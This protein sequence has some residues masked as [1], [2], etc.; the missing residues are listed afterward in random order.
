MWLMIERPQ[1]HFTGNFDNYYQVDHWVIEQDTPAYM[2]HDYIFFLIREG[3]GSIEI[4]GLQYEINGSSFCAISPLCVYKLTVA[5]GTKLTVDVIATPVYFV[6]HMDAHPPED[7]YK[8]VNTNRLTPFCSLTSEQF[9]IMDTA[10]EEFERESRIQDNV[11]K[12]MMLCISQQILYTYYLEIL[13]TY[14]IEESREEPIGYQIG[15]YLYYAN[16]LKPN[17]SKTAKKFGLT[18]R[19]MSIALQ[20]AYCADYNFI[21]QTCRILYAREMILRDISTKEIALQSGFQSQSSFF[22]TFKTITGVSFSEYRNALAELTG[23][24]GH[25]PIYVEVIRYIAENFKQPIN[26]KT[27]SDSL[28]LSTYAINYALEKRY[29]AGGSFAEQLRRLRLFYA[30]SL[31]ATTNMLVIDIAFYSGYESVHTFIRQFKN[32]FSVTPKEY[33]MEARKNEKS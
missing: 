19:E 10:F 20:N 22:G 12:Y 7:F 6:T 14:G 31:L 21:M 29:G 16:S 1:P 5:S 13:P 25:D 9:S 30:R 28:F 8:N 2:E 11:S 15:K 3:K 17:A 32:M 4:N 23:A 18:L 24:A 26:I 27:C 33:Q